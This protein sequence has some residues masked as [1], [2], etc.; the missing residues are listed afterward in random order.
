MNGETAKFTVTGSQTTV[1]QSKNTYEIDWKDKDTTAKKGNYTISEDLGDL[2]VTQFAERSQLQQ[3]AENSLM[4]ET[5]GAT[6][7]VTRT[8][9]RL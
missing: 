6:V 7:A 3:Q 8:S 2:V 4:M 9:R 1:G 5:H